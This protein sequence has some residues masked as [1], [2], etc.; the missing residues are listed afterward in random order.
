MFKAHEV[1]IQHHNYFIHIL[2]LIDKNKGLI[3]NPVPVR[4]ARSFRLRERPFV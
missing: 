1:G 2:L 4:K 3:S